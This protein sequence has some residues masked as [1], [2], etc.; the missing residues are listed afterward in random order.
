MATRTRLRKV[1]R[2]LS[3]VRDTDA[4]FEVVDKLRR[5]E[6]RLFD[7]Q[8]MKQL[9]A[10]FSSRR[11]TLLA[12]ARRKHTWTSAEDQLRA[13]RRKAKNWKPS[14]E[15]FGILSRGVARTHRSCRKAM[16]KALRRHGA[17]DFHR[18]RKQIKNLW[19]ELRLVEPA[20]PQIARDVRAL[21]R[22]ET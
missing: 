16:M 15:T 3:R 8:T 19:Y 5:K 2:A 13:L 17:D 18:L 7:A 11:K 4:M 9:R 12:A 14:R 21:H 20:S 1:A 6:K 10:W 22:A